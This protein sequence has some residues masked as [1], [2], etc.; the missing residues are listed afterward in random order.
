MNIKTLGNRA[1][2][3][4]ALVGAATLCYTG[5]KNRNANI[6]A[7]AELANTLSND[8]FN[9]VMTEA[10]KGKSLVELADSVKSNTI[11]WQKALD[12]LSLKKMP[13]IK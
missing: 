13:K 2:V 5:Q 6:K 11:S 7:K 9:K 8:Q 3:G 4:A 10:H 12:S 1:V